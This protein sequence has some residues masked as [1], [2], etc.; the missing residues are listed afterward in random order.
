MFRSNAT[1]LL[2]E[3]SVKEGRRI[4]QKEVAR[5]TNLTE[6]TLV[7]WFSNDPMIQVRSKA[8]SALCKYFEC[9][10]NDLLVMVEDETSPE[11]K[12]LLLTAFAS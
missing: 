1:K 2:L 4:T 10:M 12:T 9:T 5:A 11:S 3:K 6:T 8:V 7:H